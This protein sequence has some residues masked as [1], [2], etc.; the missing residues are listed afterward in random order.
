MPDARPQPWP[1]VLALFFVVSLI[2]ALGVAH[3][4]AFAPLYLQQLGAAPDEVPFW[5]G[6]VSAGAFVV[7][8]PL[9]PF[10][11][12]WA[13][14][15]GRKLIIARSSY[16]EALVFLLVGLSRTPL[17]LVGSMALSGFQLGN[18]GVML[19]ALTGLSPRQRLG[20]ALSVVGTAGPLGFALG[21]AVGGFLA[22]TIGL[23]PLYLADAALSLLA[24]LAVTLLFRETRH[25]AAPSGSAWRMAWDAISGI[26]REPATRLVF[27]AYLLALLGRQMASPFLP[28]LVQGLYAGDNLATMVGLVTGGTALAGALVSPG[29]GVLGDRLGYARVLGWGMAVAA[30]GAAGLALAPSLWLLG[31]AALVLGAAQS[32]VVAMCMALLATTTPEERRSP[33]LNLALLPLYIGGIAGPA[34][35]AALATLGL[36]AVFLGAVAPLL[37]G[38]GLS[39]PLGRSERAE[40]SGG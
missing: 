19:A 23:R 32:G 22:D 29:A 8:L 10:W 7:G 9:V 38:V 12:V 39:R 21:P 18:T 5:T 20:F 17:E 35:G 4:L 33:T 16:V 14:K 30:G 1:A 26:G 25:G 37:A 11:G 2:E 34:L 27:L 6:L 3:V 36:R 28:L 31:V 24:G 13:E 40:A 15:Y